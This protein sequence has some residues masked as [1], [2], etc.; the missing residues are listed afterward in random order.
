MTEKSYVDAVAIKAK[1][2]TLRENMTRLLSPNF[3]NLNDVNI[4]ILIGA[5]KMP[6]SDRKSKIQKLINDE[7]IS[8]NAEIN[9]LEE[10]F[11]LL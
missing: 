10:K 4:E 3:Q 2:Q 1:I 8:I 9:A 11:N 6:I 7:V 5:V